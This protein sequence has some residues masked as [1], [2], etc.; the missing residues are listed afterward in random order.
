YERHVVE[1]GEVLSKMSE[2]GLPYDQAKADAFSLELK[3]KWDERFADLQ[4]RVPDELK[5]S[6]QKAGYKKTPKDT[7]GLAR[8]W[9]NV[10]GD[11]MTQDERSQYAP[12]WSG[13][14]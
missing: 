13:V 2:N 8:R 1:L 6:K 7:T 9:F 4:V 10:F 3:A 5:P 11:D 14:G 12:E